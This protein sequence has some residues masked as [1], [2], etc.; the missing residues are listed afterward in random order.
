MK[1]AKCIVRIPNMYGFV[2]LIYNI[3]C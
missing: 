1:Y 3:F 2:H